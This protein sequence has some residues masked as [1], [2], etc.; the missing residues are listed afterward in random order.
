MAEMNS[1]LSSERLLLRPWKETDLEPFYQLNSDPEVMAFFPVTLSH[2]ESD[3]LAAEIQQRLLDNGWGF[4]AVQERLGNRFIGF[5]G[6]NQ[7]NLDLPF[8][9]CVEIGWRLDR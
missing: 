9:P 3:A 2:K 5:L 8:S 6:L 7:P 1:P 4:W